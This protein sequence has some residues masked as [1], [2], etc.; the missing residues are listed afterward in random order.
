MNSIRHQ[1]DQYTP[2]WRVILLSVGLLAIGLS[3]IVCF[4]R[5]LVHT[6]AGMQ[7]QIAGTG[8]TIQ[9]VQSQHLDPARLI[10]TADL[11]EFHVLLAQLYDTAAQS[12]GVQV[13]SVQTIRRQPTTA[14]TYT[15]TSSNSIGKTV[16]MHDVEAII[17]GDADALLQYLRTL[18]QAANLPVF[19]Q[20]IVYHTEAYP[21]VK[22]RVVLRFMEL[23]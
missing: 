7:E 13:H 14:F 19:W 6:Y 22:V 11:T 18:E 23:V 15:N 8:R 9:L 20:S 1:I 2:Q 12:P 21:A 10:T 3:Y 5:P 16:Y 17:A 4:I